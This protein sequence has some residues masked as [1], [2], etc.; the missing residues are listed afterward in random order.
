MTTLPFCTVCGRQL[1]ETARY[2]PACGNP[3]SEPD[4]I[5]SLDQDLEAAVTVLEQLTSAPGAIVLMENPAKKRPRRLEVAVDQGGLMSYQDRLL[6]LSLV[7][8]LIAWDAY[9]HAEVAHGATVVSCVWHVIGG[10]IIPLTAAHASAVLS[11]Y[12]DLSSEAT[13]ADFPERTADAPALINDGE[14][15][16]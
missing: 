5:E 14:P 16:R 4:E 15:V 13:S 12:E 3:T 8:E 7:A 6:I 2:C 1:P 10:D 9:L 11:V